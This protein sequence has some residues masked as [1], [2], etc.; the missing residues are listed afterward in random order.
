MA[1]IIHRIEEHCGIAVAQVVGEIDKV[2][3]WTEKILH[4]SLGK[5]CLDFVQSDLK[6]RIITK[7]DDR[8]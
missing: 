2:N 1:V 8:F 3:S 7:P 6:N 4:G 5:K